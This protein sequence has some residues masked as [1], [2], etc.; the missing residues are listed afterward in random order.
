M[1][2]QI[3]SVFSLFS[4]LQMFFLWQGLRTI[5][6]LADALPK[7]VPYVLIN[8]REVATHFSL[9][10]LTQSS[11]CVALVLFGCRNFFP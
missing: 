8:H 4:F 3:E 5:Q 6:I 7:I 10:T 1:R 9:F 2:F 11:T